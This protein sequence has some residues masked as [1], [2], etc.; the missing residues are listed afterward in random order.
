M[1]IKTVSNTE[2][3]PNTH[4]ALNTHAWTYQLFLQH[5]L[6]EFPCYFCHIA[7]LPVWRWPYVFP[8]EPLLFQRQSQYSLFYFPSNRRLC[9]ITMDIYYYYT[10]TFPC[11]LLILVPYKILC[12]K[13]HSPG[14][15]TKNQAH[16]LDLQGSICNQGNILIS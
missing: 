6:Q 4:W 3:K 9:T 16:P 8:A 7:A 5:E 12:Y 2:A 11:V 1:L 10:I 13:I 15:D 14:P